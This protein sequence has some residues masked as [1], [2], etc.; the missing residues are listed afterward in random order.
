M[1]LAIGLASGAHTSQAQEASGAEVGRTVTGYAL[2]VSSDLQYYIPTAWQLMASSDDGRSWKTLD[3]RTNMSVAS[4]QRLF[5]PVT[6]RTLY[7]T[8]RLQID[9]S[10]RPDEGI[11]ISELELQ[12]PVYGGISTNE[13]DAQITSSQEHALL[14]AAVNAFDRDTGTSWHGFGLGTSKGCWLQWKYVLHA[15]N[16]VKNAQ[17][18]L[19]QAR[20]AQARSQMSD[21]AAE[22]LLTIETPGAGIIQPLAGYA[23]VSANDSPERDPKAWELLGSNDAGRTWQSIDKRR[24]ELFQRRFQR[25]KFTLDHTAHFQS[26]RLRI[27]AIRAS[28]AANAIQ[29]AE[30]EPL[31]AGIQSNRPTSIVVSVQSENP[32]MEIAEMLFDH[33]A[34]TKWLDFCKTSVTNKSSW[35]QWQYIAQEELPVVGLQRLK[36]TPLHANG[37]IIARL[38]GVGVSWDPQRHILGFLD[39]T[40]FQLLEL[41]PVAKPIIPGNKIKLVGAIR[42][43]SQRPY[44]PQPEV[45]DLGSLPSVPSI[46]DIDFSSLQQPLVNSGVQGTVS[47]VSSDPQYFTLQVATT[48]GGRIALRIPN[49]AGLPEPKIER[50]NIEARG[51]VES[52][53]DEKARRVAGVVWVAD[54]GSIHVVPA[55]LTKPQPPPGTN[56]LATPE[57][58]TNSE[59]VTDIAPIRRQIIAHPGASFRVRVAGIVTFLD[60]GLD[61]FYLQ[62]GTGG[63]LVYSQ[64]LAGLNPFLQQ[65]GLYVELEGKT[66]G[67]LPPGILPSDAARIISKGRMPRPS[68]PSWNDLIS[69]KEDANWVE[70]DGIVRDVQDH[71]LDVSTGAGRVAVAINKIESGTLDKLLASFVRI[72]GVCSITR[73]SHGEP[74]G[75]KLLVP[76]SEFV[77]IVAFPPEDPF[78]LPT[79]PIQQIL[80]HVA[81]KGPN[82]S[83]VVKTVGVVTFVG[84]GQ[85][86]IQDDQAGLRATLRDES[87]VQPGDRVEIAG[88]AELDGFSPKLTQAVLRKIGHS[89]LSNPGP[90]EI[91]A[92]NLPSHD[93]TRGKLDAVYLGQSVKDGARVLELR[94]ENQNKV[95]YAYLPATE[96]TPLAIPE[97]SPV[98]LT[99]VFKAAAQVSPD[100]DQTIS[101][102]D[103]FLNST[104]DV[105]PLGEPPGWTAQRMFRLLGII[106]FILSVTLIA[107]VVLV[108]K[109]RA[110]KEAQSELQEAHDQLENRVNQRTAELARAKELAERAREAADAASRAKSVF[111]ATMSHEIRTPLNGVIGMSSLLLDTQLNADQRDFAFT[112]KHS[113]EA[114]LGLINDVLDFSKIEAGKVTIE[115][116]DFDLRELA[117]GALGMIQARASAKHIGLDLVVDR[118][119]PVLLRGDAGRIRQILLNLLSNA[120]KFTD[121]GQVRIEIDLLEADA[122]IA[123]IRVGVRDTGIGISQ[124]AQQRLFN[125]FEQADQSTTRKYGGTG[126]G[127]VISRRLAAIM[128]GELG[129]ESEPG[130]GSR[131]WFILPLEKQ[132]S[133]TTIVKPEESLPTE[134]PP[135][136][137]PEHPDY[138]ATATPVILGGTPLYPLRI[139]VAEDNLVNRKVALKM[140]EKLNYI[141]DVAVNGRE[142][143]EL[144]AKKPY[145]LIFMDCQMPEVDGFEATRQIRSMANSHAKVRIVAMTA[146]AMQGDR[147][148]CL[149]AGMDD[150]IAKPIQ[151]LDM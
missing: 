41:A 120:V 5:F 39:S 127:L 148:H 11:Q 115:T 87:G 106:C 57:L 90:I 65:E 17:E 116:L 132:A 71:R 93:A 146:N 113:G 110:L 31:P 63:I 102:F 108:R 94:E 69:G 81:S 48:N 143:L 8:Y 7:T 35:V 85:L 4:G 136:E 12:G 141:P 42:F 98:R 73:N 50:F 144:L 47:A 119:V 74:L 24:N 16:I 45:T 140:L 28:D 84:A 82:V 149:A 70:I 66:D 34:R 92:P 61:I 77:E 91:L 103:M 88:L 58:A 30:I 15:E 129:M 62:D 97:Q 75:I 38:E 21:R 78:K 96:T 76:S 10:D 44:L 104:R 32:P 26:Y 51:L 151:P 40:G 111:L 49:S 67:N 56:V 33:D 25:R 126:L 22:I 121:Q 138:S 105:E 60:L 100:M 112:L 1:R 125:A 36:S 46:A 59:G 117:E 23:I 54:M 52:V 14:G 130:K 89:A 95:F 2:T 80:T 123:K 19:I 29:I 18:I 134:M 20:R 37:D 79:I 109:N 124:E 145:D 107:T 43:G 147:E 72:R 137:L 118:E 55:L 133:S 3:V 64:Q 27:D 122:Q 13:I 68:R 9:R 128:N 114:L 99:G 150:Y 135:L 6:N 101:S 142:V 53:L 86:F 131:F 83:P 139:L